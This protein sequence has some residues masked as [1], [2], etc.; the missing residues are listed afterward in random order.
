MRQRNTIQHIACADKHSPAY[1]ISQLADVTRPPVIT[2]HAF[3]L[4]RKTL[5]VF[6]LLYINYL[7]KMICQPK[8]IVFA[9][10]QRVHVYAEFVEAV[11]QVFAEF[12]CAVCFLKVFI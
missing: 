4:W 10:A 3:C 12:T 1:N 8:N 7:E 6:A 2:Q 5:Y 9:F 11:I